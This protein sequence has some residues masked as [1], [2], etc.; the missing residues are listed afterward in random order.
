MA[1]QK[2]K[3]KESRFIQAREL[4]TNQA[5]PVCGGFLSI[6]GLPP[7]EEGVRLNLSCLNK[8]CEYVSTRI[9]I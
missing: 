4:F 2:Q 3:I 6:D 5:C 9:L 7:Y 8:E 1:E